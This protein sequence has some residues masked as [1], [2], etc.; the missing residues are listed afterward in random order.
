MFTHHREMVR[1]PCTGPTNKF[2][3][4]VEDFKYSVSSLLYI[5]RVSSDVLMVGFNNTIQ[6]E[7]KQAVAIR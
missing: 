7:E 3:N 1:S 2:G 4:H 6:D 5:I